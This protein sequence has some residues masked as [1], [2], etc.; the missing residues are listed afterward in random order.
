MHVKNVREVPEYEI[1]P[2]E[3]DFSNGNDIS[4]GTFRK[5]TWRGIPV[6]VKKL[7]DDLIVD[8]NKVRHSET[9]LMCCNLYAIQ[10]LC[11]FWVL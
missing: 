11:N 10:M 9:S 2:A 5:A 6:A 8:E 7:D 4:K 3:L 1:D